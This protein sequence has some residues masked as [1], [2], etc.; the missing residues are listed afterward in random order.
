MALGNGRDNAAFDGFGSHFAW[1]PMT[2]GAL[3]V[4][5]GL[6]GERHNLA[7][8]LDCEGGGCAGTRRIV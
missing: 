4:S 6:T 7:P 8:L 3:C 1:G 2:D 5:R